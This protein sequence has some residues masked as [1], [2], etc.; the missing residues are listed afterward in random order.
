M[1]DRPFP[2]RRSWRTLQ[3]MTSSADLQLRGLRARV[4]WP[5]TRCSAP[6]LLVFLT[7]GSGD[8]FCRGLCS[9]AGVVLLAAAPPALRDALRAIE[10][11]AD[12]AAELDADPKR[13]LVAGEGAGGALAAAA[14]LH[15]RDRRWPAIARQLLIH[16]DLGPP[17]GADLAGVAP[18]TVVTAT[19]GPHAD[20]GRRYA[21]RLRKAGVAVEELVV[22]IGAPEQLLDALVQS[23]A[24]VLDPDGSNVEVVTHNR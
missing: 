3:G 10:W 2:F 17:G 15:A 9:R 12:H 11:A 14:A 23:L 24:G 7:P 21:G 22:P 16:P 8:G 1:R 4:L 6:A 13:I 20:D 5:A 19:H 18:A